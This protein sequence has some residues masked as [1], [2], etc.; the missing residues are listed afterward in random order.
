M[1][2][3][4]RDVLSFKEIENALSEPFTDSD[5]SLFD[6]NNDSSVIHD[7]PVE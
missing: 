2:S 3:T 6:S 7:V 5:N 4:S 1:V